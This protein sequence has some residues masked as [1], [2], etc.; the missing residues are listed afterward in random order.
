MRKTPLFIL[1]VSVAAL[2]LLAG[3]VARAKVAGPPEIAWKDMNFK[4]KRAYMKAAV[5][6]AMKPVFQEFDAKM[7]KNF[8][9]ETCHGKDGADRKFKMPSNDIKPL[10]DTPEAFQAKMKAEATWPKWVDFMS[11]KVEPEMAK[12][13]GVPAYDPKAPVEGALSCKACHKLEHEK[14]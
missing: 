7:F 10:P 9:C 14:T 1:S 8:T 6:P 3:N 5:I 11:K 13:L 2:A 4:Q 12:L